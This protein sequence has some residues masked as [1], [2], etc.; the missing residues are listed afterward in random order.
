MC[1][2][3]AFTGSN[4]ALPFLLQGLTK[5]EYRGYDSAG[6]SIIENQNIVTIKAKGRL[7]NLVDKI[8]ANA[9]TSTIGIGHTRWAT[10]GVPSDENSHPHTSMDGKISI[11]HNGIIENYVELKEMLIDKGYQ[12]ASQTD[13]EVVVHLLSMYTKDMTMHEAIK[14][15]V[16]VIEGSYALCIIDNSLENT[17]YITKKDSP[18]VLGCDG[19]NTFAASDIPAILEYTK[20]VYFMEDFQVATLTPGNLVIQNQDDSIIDYSFTTIP[21]SQEAAKKDGYD[22]FMLKEIHDQPRALKETLR[23]RIQ[24]DYS[25]SLPELEPLKGQFSKFNRVYFIACG[26]AY[27]ACLNGASILQKITGLPA[28]CQVASEFRYDDPFIDENTLAIFASQSGETADTLAG[29]RLAKE[30]GATTLTVAN[31]LGSTLAR[32][33]NYT[34]YT[35]AGPE[36]AVAS[37][38]AY[39][40]QVALLTLLSLY[41]KQ[42]MS[43]KSEEQITICKQLLDVPT[44]VGK[45]I[46]QNDTYEKY[47]SYLYD[48][49]SAFYIGRNLDYASVMEGA[50]KIK[51]VSYIQADA[52]M[53]GELKHGSIALIE[54]GKVVIALACQPHVAKKTISNIE[55]TIARGARVILFTTEDIKVDNM[56]E[57]YYLPNVHPILQSILVAIPLQFI[58]YYVACAKGCDVD[59]PRNLAKSVTVE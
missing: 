10:H 37:T 14:K 31:V 19:E 57:I 5:L 45:L 16:T 33:A 55:E 32:E 26:T 24:N 42:D 21:F 18:I 38:K 2:I 58:A 59:K 6:V 43:G 44:L 30:K 23:G 11:V 25:I 12:F 47:A 36:I 22:T 34:L 49:Q 7:Q 28:V 56:D 29:L 13:S 8:G 17:I 27:H 50:L 53:A 48:Q 20:D 3:T 46:E 40:T 51:E 4:Q 39:T 9:P 35:L 52:Y 15:V 1:G 41:I 54:P